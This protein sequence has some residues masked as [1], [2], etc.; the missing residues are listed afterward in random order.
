MQQTPDVS[1]FTADTRP[2]KSTAADSSAELQR[3]K[4]E[5]QRVTA[6]ATKLLDV[7]TALSDA[8]SVEDVTRVFLSKGVEVVEATRGVIVAVEGDRLKV[9]GTRGFTP[10]LDAQFAN[11]TRD[12]GI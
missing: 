6:L 11:L 10:E 2:T 12:S 1:S 5:L 3:L 9:L 7:T 8:R 4:E